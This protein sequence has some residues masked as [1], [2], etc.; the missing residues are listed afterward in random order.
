MQIL[1]LLFIVFLAV[2][3]EPLILMLIWNA[4]APKLFSWPE[5]G[6]CE[7]AGIVVVCNILFGGVFKRS[8]S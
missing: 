1:I 3:I 4:L 5:I 2:S 6:F 7:A 8:N